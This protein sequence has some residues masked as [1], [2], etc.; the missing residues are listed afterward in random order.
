MEPSIR[1]KVT[2]KLLFPHESASYVVCSLNGEGKAIVMATQKHD[3]SGKGHILS[4]EVEKLE[5]AKPEGTDFIDRME[6]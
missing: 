4:V 3:S 5:G 2:F 6:W 1:Y